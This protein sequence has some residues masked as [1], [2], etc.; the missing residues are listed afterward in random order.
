MDRGNRAR[1]DAFF[2][3]RGRSDQRQMHESCQQHQPDKPKP[4]KTMPGRYPS[5]QGQ[6]QVILDLWRQAPESRVVEVGYF[7][8]RKR[9]P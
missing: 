2:I 5:Q 9:V 3:G 8:R 6:Q 4:P 7:Q 1:S